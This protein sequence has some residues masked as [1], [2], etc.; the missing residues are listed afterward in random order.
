VA[1]CGLNTAANDM[2]GTRA[3]M[4][5]ANM[6]AHLRSRKDMTDNLGIFIT[7]SHSLSGV[8]RAFLKKRI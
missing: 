2:F 4:T 8:H 3:T 1:V 6:L 5:A 7:S